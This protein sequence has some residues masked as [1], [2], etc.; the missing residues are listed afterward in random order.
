MK[1]IKNI[2]IRKK[3]KNSYEKVGVQFFPIGK[4]ALGKS[5]PFNPALY[6][7]DNIECSFEKEVK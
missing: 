2:N 3:Y 6:K 4:K 7:L 5:Q 1:F